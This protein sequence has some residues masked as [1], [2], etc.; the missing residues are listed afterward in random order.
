MPAPDDSVGMLE[1]GG[2]AT[3]LEAIRASHQRGPGPY[4]PTGNG[5]LGCGQDWPCDTAQVLAIL[6]DMRN[7]M[8]MTSTAY[9]EILGESLAFMAERDASREREK[10][11]AEALRR[12]TSFTPGYLCWCAGMPHDDV[13]RAALTAFRAHE[14]AQK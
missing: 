4:E 10:A 5:C 11:L 1:G 6:D 7:A 3:L 2:N 12:T 13:C 9:G 8:D 14:E